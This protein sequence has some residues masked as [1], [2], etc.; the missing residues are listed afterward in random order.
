MGAGAKSDP[1]R[2]QIADISNTIYDPLARSVRRGLRLHGV[3][4]GIP[5]VYSTEVPGEVKLLPLPEDEFK[6]G[7]VNELGVFD[8]FRVRILPVLGPMP[9]IFGLNMAMVVMCDLARKPIVNPLGIKYRKKVYEKLYRALVD[10]ES[11]IAR[12][13]IK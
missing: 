4:S 3:H 2:I 5:V 11:R 9:A 8:D 6:K 10:C 12:R 1:T 13:Q 7:S